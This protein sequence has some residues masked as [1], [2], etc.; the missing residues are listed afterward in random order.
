MNLV[1]LLVSEH[2]CKSNI[3]FCSYGLHLRLQL[4]MIHGVQ[5]VSI[6]FFSAKNSEWRN[7][8]IV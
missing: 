8:R 4:S 1:V 3:Y 2:D 6:S 5:N 7:K